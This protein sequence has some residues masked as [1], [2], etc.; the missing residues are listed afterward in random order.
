MPGVEGRER[1]ALA[2]AEVWRRLNEPAVL[3]RCIPGCSGFERLEDGRYRTTLTVAVGAVRGRYEGTVA[4]RDVEAPDRC[5]IVVDG[6]GD[7]GSI[8]GQG[9][10]ALAG[11]GDATEVTYRG[12]FKLTGAVAGVGQRLAPGLSRRMI[13]ETLRNLERDGSE[14][15][16]PPPASADSAA[17]PAQPLQP[18]RVAPTPAAEF[19]PFAVRRL[20][21]PALCAAA[22]LIALRLIVKMAR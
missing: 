7:K 12:T 22:G 6:R 18:S 17:A 20:A 11:A 15:A 4:Y 19:R 14:S 2:P 13:V 21:V 1:L 16:A 9:E 5:T 3:A 8:A 10:I